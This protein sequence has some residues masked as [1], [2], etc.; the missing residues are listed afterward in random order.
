MNV[1]VKRHLADQHAHAAQGREV[2]GAPKVITRLNWRSDRVGF[3]DESY[4]HIF[5]IP[6]DGGT[7]R[8]ITNGDWNH[9]ARRSRPTGNS[10]RSRRCA[11]RTPSMRSASRRSTSP[12]S[13]PARSSS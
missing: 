10:S 3:T 13:R 11:S 8:Q 5:V 7:A 4:R 2:D 12:I 9:S 1:P 6:A